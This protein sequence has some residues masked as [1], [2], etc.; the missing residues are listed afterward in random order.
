MDEPFCTCGRDPE[1]GMF[2]ACCEEHEKDY[3]EYLENLRAQK[4]GTP[5]EAEND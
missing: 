1:S 2:E 4:S 5:K 3:V